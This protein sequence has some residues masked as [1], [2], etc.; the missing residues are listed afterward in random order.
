MK[1]AK[2]IDW[3]RKNPTK[4][5]IPDTVNLDGCLGDSWLLE[6]VYDDYGNVKLHGFR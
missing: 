1:L 3:I 4:Q 6:K 2:F 5:E